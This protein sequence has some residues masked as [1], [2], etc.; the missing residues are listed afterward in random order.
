MCS[1]PLLKMVHA[2]EHRICPLHHN[3]FPDTR[4]MSS[5]RPD[6][7]SRTTLPQMA[8][9]CCL[10]ATPGAASELT[11]ASSYLCLRFSPQLPTIHLLGKLS[12][13]RRVQLIKVPSLGYEEII[14]R[15]TIAYIGECI[16]KA[17]IK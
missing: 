1:I 4:Q 13:P 12:G 8:K 11:K 7:A 10:P 2:P 16:P 5:P 3:T 9:D 14:A 6:P 17:I 15:K